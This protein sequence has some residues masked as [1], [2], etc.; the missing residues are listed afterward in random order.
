MP[1]PQIDLEVGGQRFGGWQ[2][3]SI[4]MGIDRAARSFQLTVASRDEV[5]RPGSQCLVLLDGELVVTGYVDSVRVTHAKTAHITTVAGRSRTCD[6]VD[7][8]ASP[9]VWGD[10]TNIEVPSFSAMMAEEYNVDVVLATTRQL[11]PIPTYTVNPG[12]KVFG[13]IENLCRQAKLFATDDE[14]G[15]LVLTDIGAFGTVSSPLIVDRTGWNVLR[16]EME[17]NLSQRYGL[18]EVRGETGHS[19]PGQEEN[20]SVKSDA[21]VD[22]IFGTRVRNLYLN[23]EESV[24]SKRASERAQWEAIT[25][26]GRSLRVSTVV[27]G[28][29][30]PDGNLWDHN[31]ILRYVDRVFGLDQELSVAAVDFTV[32]TQG[33]LTRLTLVPQDAYAPAPF[34]E[35]GGVSMPVATPEPFAD[36]ED[37]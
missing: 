19:D 7:C 10:H 23:A 20:R 36:L 21:V 25:R 2:S 32:D 3:M 35:K 31:T 16:S 11:D 29:R 27:N 14:E 13:V 22:E 37:S 18:Y 26:A 34:T 28:W 4:S 5:V 8:S 12:T 17:S 15:R 30:D 33:V 9:A 24:D 6:L 1:F